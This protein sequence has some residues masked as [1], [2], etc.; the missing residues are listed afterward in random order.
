MADDSRPWLADLR[1]SRGMSQQE[2]ADRLGVDAGTVG[3]W[4]RGEQ[5]IRERN[6]AALAAA[7]D[8]TMRQLFELSLT[9]DDGTGMYASPSGPSGPIAASDSIVNP[10]DS[11]QQVVDG[12]RGLDHSV[13]PHGVLQSVRAQLAVIE[14]MGSQARSDAARSRLLSLAAET[15][16][17]A[18]WLYFDTLDLDSARVSFGRSRAAADAAGNSALLAFILGPTA[19]FAEADIGNRAHGLDL[20][21]AAMGHAR[22]SGNERLVGFTSAIAARVL[23]KLGD[24]RSAKEALDDAQQAL[25]AH[26]D[27]KSDPVWLHV[28]DE[29]ALAGHAGSVELDL[30]QPSNAVALLDR[31]DSNANSLFVRNRAIWRLDRAAAYRDMGEIDRACADVGH[32][33]DL[34]GATSSPRTRW[35]LDRLTKSLVSEHATSRDV[36]ILIERIEERVAT[37][38]R[39]SRPARRGRLP[40]QPSPNQGRLWTGEN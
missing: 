11:L 1:R 38:T 13:G 33:L 21:Y 22:R 29:T 23:A 31:Q 25:G 18:G 20:A 28:F 16:Q 26:Q 40:G 5:D 37:L 10:A 35:K 27:W 9:G 17:L 19:A 34:V 14:Q 30:G 3:R 39:G 8:L 2:L 24:E 32:A 6:K 4:E 12:L 15:H 36:V 7:L